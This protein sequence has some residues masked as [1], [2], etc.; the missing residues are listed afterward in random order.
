MNYFHRRFGESSLFLNVKAQMRNVVMVTLLALALQ[1]G[2]HAQINLLANPSGQDGGLSGW[3]LIANGGDGWTTSG[4]S[5]DGDGSSFITS[6][7]WCTRSQTIDLLAQGYTPEFLDSSPPILV[8]ES[9]KGVSNTADLYFLRVELRDENGNVL[10]SW[11]AG[12]QIAPLIAS[13]AWVLEEHR[14]RNYPTGVREIYWEDGGDDAEFWLG[15]YG[16]LLDG[17]ELAF[18]DPPPKSLSLNP[19][20]YP[21]NAPRGGICGILET[22]DNPD[23]THIYDLVGE[24]ANTTLV[25]LQTTWSYLDDGSD[26]GVDWIQLGFDDGAWASG[27]AEIGYGEA[28]EQTTIAGQGTHFT[29]YFRH[30]FTL[31]AGTLVNIS[32]LALRVKRDDGAVVYLNGSEIVRENLP[33]GP[34]AFNTAA[35]L[36]PDDGQLFHVF[37]I[38]PALLVAG[39]NVLAVEVH[40][41]NLTSSDASFDLE[42]TAETITN[43]F[44]NDLFE[45]SGDQLRFAQS[46]RSL[47]VDLED[48]WTVNIRTTDN[49]GNSLTSQFEVTAVSNPTQIPTSI[50][51]SSLQVNDGQPPGTIVGDLTAEDADDGDLHL[52]E[53]VPGEGSS[54]NALFVVSGTRLLTSDVL[55]VVIQ[56]TAQIRIRATDRAGLFTEEAFNITIVEFNNPP[57]DLTLSD[58]V[59]VD[60][61]GAGALLGTLTTADLDLNDIHTYA[62]TSVNRREEIFGFGS[63]WRFLDNNTD[64]GGFW[65]GLSFDDSG[66]KPGTGS[67]GYGDAQ[68]TLVDFGGDSANRYPTTY[69]RRSFQ[70]SKVDRFE[71]YEVLV[72][73]DDGV[74]VYLNGHEVGRD[75]LVESADLT[76][77][78]NVAIGGVDEVTP[79]SF[80]IDTDRISVGDNILAAEV[81][82][83]ALGSS[84]LTFDLSL[85]GLVDAT[86]S[87]YFVVTNGNEIRTTEAF[88]SAGLPA[89]PLD[90]TIRTTDAFGDFLE[91]IFTIEMTSDNPNDIDNDDLPDDWELTH[92]GNIAGQRGSDDSDGDGELNLDEYRFG[93]RPNDPTSKLD[94]KVVEMDDRYIV[95]WFSSSRH[96]YRL[97]SSST[98]DPDSWVDTQNGQRVGTDA[99]IG[100]I[101]Q[102]RLRPRKYFFRLMVE[103]L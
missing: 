71:G 26:L 27:Q 50:S 56:S 66:W 61:A 5:V 41:V 28:D 11:E 55:N 49:G 48:N 69:F 73:R 77:L 80:S 72:R 21:L 70:L 102:N 1:G 93:T 36:A 9:F 40:Q 95:E 52:Y 100:E 87:Q 6:Y 103:E 39:E 45:V 53:L 68:D 85:V 32:G 101:F 35:T 8:R 3:S 34:I 22:G 43:N 14:F 19:G 44:D 57:S 31:D 94:F 86:P 13:G 46:G 98:L 89:G 91:R 17:A 90:L 33:S 99:V 47:S 51:L 96:S 81:H 60:D 75:N 30:R 84:D 29:N 42:L 83:S 12:N 23:A 2:S 38:D 79:I 63:E 74:A 67:F 4:D 59:L 88:V 37:V 20:T 25:P 65:K 62:I 54:D 10:E 78:A 76:T 24:V 97:Q 92:F 7:S 82:Q 64:P 15:H 16:T 18:D 58:L